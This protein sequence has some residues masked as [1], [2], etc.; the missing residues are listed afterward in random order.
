MCVFNDLAM[1][2]CDIGEGRYVETF[3][4][5]DTMNGCPA[6]GM[7]I[8][9]FGVDKRD[10]ALIGEFRTD[11]DGR[12]GGQLLDSSNYR[13]GRYELRFHVAPYFRSLGVVLPEP[14]F[15]DIVT[16]AFGIAEPSGSYHVPLLVSPWSYSTY[17][18]S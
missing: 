7:R 17:R 18:G 11:S 2:R 16:V 6:S 1:L 14:A 15:I 5:L 3:D 13:T 12:T 8:E 10:S 4:V 9:F